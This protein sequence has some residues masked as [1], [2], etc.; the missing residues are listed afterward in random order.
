MYIDNY[1][2]LNLEDRI[3]II[4]EIKEYIFFKEIEL[5]VVYVFN[6]LIFVSIEESDNDLVV[7]VMNVIYEKRLKVIY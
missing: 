1:K 5:I 4:E 7:K 6:Y 2:I 3:I